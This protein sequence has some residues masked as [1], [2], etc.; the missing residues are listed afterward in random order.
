MIFSSL[1][2]FYKKNVNWELIRLIKLCK[3]LN[4]KIALIT[5][6]LDTYSRINNIIEIY[7]LP[8]SIVKFIGYENKGE[9]LYELGVILHFNKPENDETSIRN[10]KINVV[11]VYP[12]GFV[13]L[14]K[15]VQ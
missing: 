5:N 14:E 11:G 3:K 15:Y 6:Y 12:D 13:G 8:V 7:E 9:I 4:F 10:N 1:Y 2:I